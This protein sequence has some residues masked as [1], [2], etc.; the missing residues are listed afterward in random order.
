MILGTLLA[1]TGIYGKLI[2]YLLALGIL[3]PPLGGVVIGDFLARW[4]N[5]MPATSALPGVEWR[6]LVVYVVAAQA[7]WASSEVGFFIPP[8]IGVVVAVLGVLAVQRGR[9]APETVAVA[10]R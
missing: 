3:I 5:G 10:A 7:A 1:I 6:N 4:R 8:V 9:P 2:D